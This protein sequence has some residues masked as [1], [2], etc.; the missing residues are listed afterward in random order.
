MGKESIKFCQEPS[1]EYL[2][3]LEDCGNDPKSVEG[4][5]ALNKAGSNAERGWQPTWDARDARK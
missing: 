3:K 4:F 2:Q 5:Y 1:K